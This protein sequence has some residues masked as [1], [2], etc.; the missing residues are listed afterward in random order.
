MLYTFSY[1]LNDKIYYFLWDIESGSLHLTDYAAYLICKDLYQKEALDEA[2]KK[3]LISFDHNVKDEIV[4]ELLSLE[5]SGL[6]NM[7]CPDYHFNS[8]RKEIKALCLH[9]CHDCN[10]KCRYCFGN[11]GTYNTSRDYM[12]IETGRAAIDFLIQASGERKSLEVD[13]FGG[14]PLLNMD[15]VKEIVNYAEEHAKLH[16]KEFSFTITTNAILLN[17][18]NI[19]FLNQKMSNVVIS[20]DGRR[21][22][23]N[24]VRKTRN[25]KDCYDHIINNALKFRKIRGDGQYYIRGT[26]TRLN[27]NFAEDVLHLNDLGFDQISIEPVVLPDN[28]PLALGKDQIEEVC[29]QYELLA[30]EYIKRRKTTEKWFNFF[31]FMIDLENGPCITKRLTGCGAGAEYLAISPTGD[32]YPCHQFVGKK[33]FLMGS[34][35]EDNFNNSIQDKFSK[36]NVLSKEKCA[37]CIAKYFCSGGCVANSYNFMKDINLPYEGGCKMMQK[38]F[39]LSLAIYAIENLI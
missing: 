38:R 1:S 6:I 34:V 12:D 25:N 11:E 13:F 31:H 30:E 4:K 3:D 10:L 39:E 32:I 24:E 19:E 15:T 5:Q 26:F 27:P 33:E 18:A 14:E 20:I 21:E 17:D 28:H 8:K 29:R 23:H 35:F 9:I 36:I 16:N 22:V 7:P 37:N 2:E